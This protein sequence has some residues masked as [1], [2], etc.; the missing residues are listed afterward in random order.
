V[1]FGIE[2]LDPSDRTILGLLYQPVS[3]SDVKYDE[4]EDDD[5]DE[6][7]EEEDGTGLGGS[8]KSRSKHKEQLP[9]LLSFLKYLYSGNYPRLGNK[10][11]AFFSRLQDLGLHTQPRGRDELEEISPFTPR[12]LVRSVAVQLKAELQKMYKNGSCELHKKV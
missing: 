7:E 6:E 8:K 12:D 9:F 10:V 1:S 5:D 3:M 2:N 4:D 11:S